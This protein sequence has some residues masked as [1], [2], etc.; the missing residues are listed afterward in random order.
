M[1]TPPAVRVL[2]V[3]PD[4]A[5]VTR[6]VTRLTSAGIVCGAASPSSPTAMR[7]RHLEAPDVVVAVEVGGSWQPT[8]RILE[9]DIAVAGSHGGASAPVLVLSDGAGQ[10]EKIETLS[11]AGS[12]VWDW[13]E[14]TVSDEEIIARIGRLARI[15]RMTEEI[16]E[17][18]RRCAGM[19]TIDRLTGLPNH[20]A[21]QEY[22]TTEFRRAERYAAPLSLLL[23]DF[24]RFRSLNETHGHQWGDRVLQESARGVRSLLREVDM[25]SRFG[26][27]ELVLLLPQTDATAAMTVAARVRGLIESVPA[28]MAPAQ[29]EP[30]SDDAGQPRVTASIGVATFPHEATATRG[31]LLAAAESALRRAKDEG[32]NRSVLFS[33]PHQTPPESIDRP[34]ELTVDS[35]FR[36]GQSKMT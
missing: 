17:L 30:S 4:Q 8:V 21:F 7:G 36:F 20:R 11:S 10:R 6:V 23:V 24:D 12:G 19:E 29:T 14:I 9:R 1:I 5:R 32:R 31:Q 16:E 35:A 3:G 26:G 13:V 22:L 34:A 15:G 25:V 18:T 2:V 27:E 28:R 33:S